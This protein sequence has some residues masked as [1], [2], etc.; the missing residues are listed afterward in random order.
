MMLCFWRVARDNFPISQTISYLDATMK[1]VHAALLC[2]AHTAMSFESFSQT[3]ARGKIKYEFQFCATMLKA[4]H[5]L[6]RTK[7]S[8][9]KLDVASPWPVDCLPLLDRRPQWTSIHWH[10][11]LVR[12]AL[13]LAGHFRSQTVLWNPWKVPSESRGD[14]VWRSRSSTTICRRWYKHFETTFSEDLRR[15]LFQYSDK[16]RIIW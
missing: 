5:A 11:H 4:L 16:D 15:F 3:S 13:V 9:S 1:K 2:Q 8:S 6:K 12:F 10:I 7:E 14:L